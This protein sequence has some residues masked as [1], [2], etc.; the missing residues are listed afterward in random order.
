M[1]SSGHA[2]RG[3][4]T[5]VALE[6]LARSGLLGRCSTM[7][8]SRVV[9]EAELLAVHSKSAVDAIFTAL[10]EGS[11]QR[12]L[13]GYAGGAEHPDTYANEHTA[14]VVLGCAALHSEAANR[15]AMRELDHVMCLT[16]P[17]GHHAGG[18]AVFSGGCFVNNVAVAVAAARQT[19]A[20]RRVLV[21]D[22]DVHHGDGTQQIFYDKP[23]VL[24]IS[25]HR[26]EH[27]P[28]GFY[29]SSGLPSHC[30]SGQGAGFNVNLAFV[31]AEGSFEDRRKG[32]TRHSLMVM[33]YIATFI[34]IVPKNLSYCFAVDEGGFG[35]G[36][37]IAVFEHLVL[38][39]ARSFAPELVVIAAGFDSARGDPIG[40]FDLTCLAYAGM[41]SDLL[42]L[43][44]LAGRGVLLTLEGGYNPGIIADSLEA[45][46]RVMLSIDGVSSDWCSRALTS[47]RMVE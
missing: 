19:G 3:S 36:D 41:L 23:D 32:V 42:A 16:R 44:S 31:Y 21:L 15:V 5:H 28:G 4:R 40:G 34:V 24:T 46:L 26:F 47:D 29:P 22:W 39:I 37:Y 10:R 20:V 35:D 17:P 27:E 1:W 8:A 9:D 13:S 12:L 14:R 11:P 30:G 18:P 25:L 45:G 2:T 38:P 43:P 7:S 33:L 6:Q